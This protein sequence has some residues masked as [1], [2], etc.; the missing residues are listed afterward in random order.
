[1]TKL[2]EAE[3]QKRMALYNQG[4]TD[5]EIAD[6]L[7][8]KREKITNWRLS[9][10][11]KLNRSFELTPEQYKIAKRFLSVLVYAHKVNP[12]LDVGRFMKEYRYVLNG[13]YNCG[14]REVEPNE[15]HS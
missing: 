2:S 10:G 13:H 7:N 8:Y 6:K 12:G 11:L 4:L 5:R 14:N 1:M 15:M 3:E 9:R